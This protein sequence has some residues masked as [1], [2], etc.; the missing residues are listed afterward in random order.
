MLAPSVNS[1]LIIDRYAIYGEIAAGGMAT[2][3]LTRLIGAGGFSKTVAVKRLL[4][5]LTR[6][7]DFALMLID[8]ARLAARIR[9]PNV[10]STLDVVSSDGELLLVMEYVHG[11]SLAKLNRKV[12]EKGQQIPIPIA[13]A[14]V[15]DALHGLHAAHEAKSEHGHPLNLVHRDISPQNLMVGVDGVTRIADFGIA[16]AFGRSYVTRDRRIKG[17]LAYMAPEQIHLEP[18]SRVTDVFAASVVFWEVL[19]G[20]RLFQGQNDAQLIHSVLTSE[21]PPP[22]RINPNLPPALDAVLQRGLSREPE[23]RFATAREMALAIESCVVP[24]RPSEIGRWVEEVAKDS[25]AARARAIAAIERGPSA[26][27]AL[28]E[29]SDPANAS[30]L[31]EVEEGTVSK[32]YTVDTTP[33]RP[34]SRAPV[35]FAPTE[36]HTRALIRTSKPSVSVAASASATEPSA[37]P[38]RRQR[39]L[40]GLGALLLTSLGAGLTFWVLSNPTQPAG[41]EAIDPGRTAEAPQDIAESPASLAT[42]TTRSPSSDALNSET[43]QAPPSSSASSEAELA[44]EAEEAETSPKA[45]AAAQPRRVRPRKWTAPKTSPKKSTSKSST[46]KSSE[47]KSTE[48]TSSETKSPCDPPYSIDAQGRRIFKLECM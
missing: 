8:E 9:H 27:L 43:K 7:E 29:S 35:A 1:P 5:H 45:T 2:V 38:P 37:S 14:I 28:P 15:I 39:L 40:F 16:K 3:H 26:E 33:L 13:A 30:G 25:L 24:V 47:T 34:N 17:K 19:T 4:P 48:A 32:P 12:R 6:D 18:V 22:S 20:R 21:I 46:A 44:A 23:Q 41:A 11:E 42:E 31:R 36:P 10:V